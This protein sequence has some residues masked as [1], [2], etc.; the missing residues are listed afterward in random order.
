MF[1]HTIRGVERAREVR[2]AFLIQK[3]PATMSGSETFSPFFAADILT[4][5]FSA[6]VLKKCALIGMHPIAEE[7][8][9]ESSGCRTRI[10]GDMWRHPKSPIWKVRMQLGLR[11]KA[12]HRVFLAKTTCAIVRCTS[13]GCMGLVTWFLSLPGGLGAC[14]GGIKLSHCPGCVVSRCMRPGSW[15]DA[16]RGA[17]VSQQDEP[18]SHRG[19]AVTTK[20]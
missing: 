4:P 16:A 2:A 14:E 15:V 20:E 10:F 17:S 3:K 6:D 1:T 5:F 13:S 19:R 18:F 12:F 11:T 9:V 7:G 8:R